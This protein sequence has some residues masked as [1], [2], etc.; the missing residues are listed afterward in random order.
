MSILLAYLKHNWIIYSLLFIYVVDL[1]LNT[2]GIHIWLPQC[3]VSELTGYECFGCG[4]NRAAMAML[5]GDFVTA[6][7]FNPLI[8]IYS[9]LLIG[10]TTYNYYKFYLRTNLTNYE[11]HG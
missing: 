5:S 1:L 4:L 11:K 7:R 2:I 9:P 6:F 8:Y 10:W 3:L